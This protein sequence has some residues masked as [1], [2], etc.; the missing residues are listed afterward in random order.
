[1][2]D[3]TA[4]EETTVSYDVKIEDAGPACKA[5][6]ITIPADRIKDKIEES[7]GTLQ[8]DA[9]LPGFRRGRAPRR[10]LEK[11]FASSIG[12]DVKNQLLS[13]SYSKA[14]EDHELDVLGDPEIE[15]IEDLKLPEE[16]N[17]TYTVKVEVTPNVELPK[18]DTLKL[19]KTVVAVTDEQVAEELERVRNQAGTPKTIEDAPIQE[20]DYAMVDTLIL[21]GEDAGA[22]AETIA[23]YPAA[24]VLVHGEDK[25]Y[26]GHV[27]G[28]LIE[29]LGKEMLGKKVGDVVTISMTGPSSHE[30][31]KIKDQ[32]ITVKME[33]TTIHRIEPA[34]IEDIIERMGLGSE[35]ELTERVKTSLEQRA[36]QNQK[37]DLYQQAC[38]QLVEQVA[39]ELPKG[40]SSRQTE[41]VLQRQTM[42]MMYRG[43]PANEIDE[44][45]A[46]LR[47]ESEEAAQRQLK[48]FFILDKASK[49]LDVDVSEQELNGR[50]AMMAMQSGRRPEK[51]RQEM[52]Q[53]GQIEQLYLQI[54]EQK[55][56][57]KIIEQA[58]VTEVEGG[59][60]KPAAK[61]K[62]TKKKTS[63]KKSTQKKDDAGE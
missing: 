60:D 52:M 4:T 2:A 11:R 37:A 24:H 51:V 22:D 32:P 42:D 26:K 54:R 39:L 33:V 30:E 27:A 35:D 38:D 13:E 9:V 17:L 59:D 28:I 53:H 14:L 25:D 5:L 63:K 23:H 40:I 57:D 19:N 6:T 56:L 48:Q 8:T 34:A 50:I 46:E 1:M 7:Y 44:K 18:F 62:S 61:K 21:A 29:N 49:D 3:E 36:E 20:D 43:T 15:G 16:G 47:T 10:L 58:S 41:R 31:E 55:T 45:L 12:D